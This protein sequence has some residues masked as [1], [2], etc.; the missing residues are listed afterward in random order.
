MQ[1]KKQ[2]QPYYNKRKSVYRNPVSYA[3]CNNNSHLKNNNKDKTDL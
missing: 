2:K 1:K 3:V